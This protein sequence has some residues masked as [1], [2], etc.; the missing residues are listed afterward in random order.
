MMRVASPFVLFLNIGDGLQKYRVELSLRL[1]QLNTVAIGNLH[2]LNYSIWCVCKALV[3][4]EAV[5][6]LIHS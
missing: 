2:P 4:V 5:L 1:A 3:E 6:G